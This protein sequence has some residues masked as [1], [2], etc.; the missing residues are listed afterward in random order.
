MQML[1]LPRL[2]I[3]I[4]R[5][6]LFWPGS[7][8]V[9]LD[10]PLSDHGIQQAKDIQQFLRNPGPLPEEL[11]PVLKD[12][13]SKTSSVVVSSNLR[14]AIATA[15]VGLKDKL[16]KSGDTITLLSCLQEISPNIDTLALAKAHTVPTMTNVDKVGVRIADCSIDH[17]C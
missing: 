13:Q 4:I 15:C 2:L 17:L 5:E 8:S 10:S 11:Q 14:R 6:V 16:R 7:D 3:A 9:F 12:L 1:L